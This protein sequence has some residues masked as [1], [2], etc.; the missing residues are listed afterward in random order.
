MNIQ[1]KTCLSI[2]LNLISIICEIKTTNIV[3]NIS[4]LNDKVKFA[5]Q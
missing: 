1:H 5:I 3:H 2:F 4:V